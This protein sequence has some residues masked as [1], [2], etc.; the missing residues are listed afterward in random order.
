M[1]KESLVFCVDFDGTC[2]SHEFPEIG[3]D[4]GSVEVLKRIV[5]NGHK[6]VLFTMRGN[7]NVPKTADGEFLT[8]ANNYLEKAVDWFEENGIEL[9]GINVNPTQHHWTN[10]PKAFGNIYIDDAA[11]GCPLT[12][13]SDVSKRP[14]VDWEEIEYI[15]VKKGL[16]EPE[17]KFI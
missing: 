8:S 7:L 11:I 5:R 14:F 13:N 17:L 2:V 4:I 16:L 10:S 12:H 3:A 15:L 1:K 6:L 9:H